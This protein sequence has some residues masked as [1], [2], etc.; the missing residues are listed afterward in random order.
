MARKIKVS[1]KKI[2]R[3]DEFLTLSD[4]FFKYISENKN[5]AYGAAGG[6]VLVLLA[7]NLGIYTFKT[8]QAKADLLLT[9][10]FSILQTPLAAEMT[11]EQVLKGAKSFSSDEQ[12]SQ[13]AITKLGEVVKKFGSSEPGLEARYHLGALYYSGHDYN[14]SVS[15]FEDFIKALKGRGGE[16]EYLS[17]SAYLGIAKSYFA[18]GDFPKAGENYQKVLDAKP[19]TAYQS[20]AM[21]GE[22]RSLAA[23]GKTDQA[24]DL[25]KDIIKTYP[26]SIYQQLADLEIANLSK[27]KSAEKS[28]SKGETKS[29]K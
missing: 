6:V 13:E 26:G 14:N 4:R 28:Q 27:V 3:P 11:Q 16:M 5:I 29:E 15:N 23:Q 20:E 22:A 19:P 21:L 18:M 1:R 25:L 24:R 9:E 7:V 2:K 8:R 17:Y 12:R 10:A